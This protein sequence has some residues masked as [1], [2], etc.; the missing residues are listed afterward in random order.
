[1]SWTDLKSADLAHVSYRRSRLALERE[2]GPSVLIADARSREKADHVL[3]LRVPMSL[4]ER[5]ARLVDG[6]HNVALTAIIEDALDRL[7]AGQEA[8][9]VISIR[10]AR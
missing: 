5:V 1:M 8:W 10:D 7:E 6:S 3:Y 9:R 2:P 4:H